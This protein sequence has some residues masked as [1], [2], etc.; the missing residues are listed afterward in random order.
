M[1]GVGGVFGAVIGG[2]LTQNDQVPLIF[3]GLAGVG[4]S[5]MIVGCMMDRKLD[6]SAQ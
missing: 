1:Y 4:A 3:F 5:L 6:T 2:I